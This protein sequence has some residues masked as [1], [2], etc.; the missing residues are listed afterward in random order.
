MMNL[1]SDCTANLSLGVEAGK[2]KIVATNGKAVYTLAEG[3]FEGEL[4]FTDIPD[5]NYT[6]KAVGVEAKFSLKLTY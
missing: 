4:D 2:F 5:G 6:V 3:D 1:S